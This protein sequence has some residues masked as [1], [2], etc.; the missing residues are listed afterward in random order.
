MSILVLCMYMSV[1]IGM[2]TCRFEVLYKGFVCAHEHI[3]IL[4]MYVSVL[5][6]I[7]VLCMYM[8]VL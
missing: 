7:L 5:V 3:L 8:S 6:S 2:H 1:L 4:G